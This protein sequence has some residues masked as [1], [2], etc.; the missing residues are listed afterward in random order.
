[1]VSGAQKGPRAQARAGTLSLL[2]LLSL[3]GRATAQCASEPLTRGGANVASAAPW[4]AAQSGC[5]AGRA[6]ASLDKQPAS[7]APL[8][9]NFSMAAA[10]VLVARDSRFETSAKLQDHTGSPIASRFDIPWQITPGPAPAWVRQ[11]VPQWITDNAKNYR[12]RG[13]PLLR[14]WESS[15]Y[16]VALG[17]N[18]HGVPGAYFTQKLP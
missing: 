7:S 2:L 11:N 15:H 1:M 8:A 12:R 18:N 6:T 17:L 3:T 13:L 4:Q 14:L 16:M 9:S 10:R 5:R